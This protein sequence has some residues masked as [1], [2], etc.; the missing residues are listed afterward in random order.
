M[1]KEDA[2]QLIL[3]PDARGMFESNEMKILQTLK[4][5]YFS[6]VTVISQ[7]N[8]LDVMRQLERAHWFFQGNYVKKIKHHIC[9]KDQ[10]LKFS[11]IS[12]YLG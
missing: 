1:S 3:E 8:F 10:H 11:L 7:T 12:A 9:F 4:L 2:K 6:D 5:Q